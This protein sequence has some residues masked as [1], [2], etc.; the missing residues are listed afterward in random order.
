MTKT[1]TVRANVY[2]HHDGEYLI[3]VR[4]VGEVTATSHRQAR[5]FAIDKYGSRV[6]SVAVKVTYP[7]PF[8]ALLA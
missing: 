6:V 1:Y 5:H 4:E 8:A 2:I 3:T 7:D